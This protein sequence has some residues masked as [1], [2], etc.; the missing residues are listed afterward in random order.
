MVTPTHIVLDSGAAGRARTRVVSAAV[1]R[2]GDELAPRPGGVRDRVRPGEAVRDRTGRYARVI[3]VGRHEYG[4]AETRR[5]VDRLRS[6]IVPAAQIPAGLGVYAGGAPAQGADFLTQSYDAFPWLVGG[7]LALTF[8]ILMRAFRSIVLPL[9]AVAVNALSTAAIYG[10]LVVVFRWGVG[11]QLFGLPH[12]SE[13]DGMDPDL[14]VRDP[15][16]AVDGLRGLLVSRMREA[17]DETED[18]DRAVAYG[19]ERTGRIITAAALIMCAAFLGS[20]RR[21]VALQ[22]FGVGLALAVLID[23]TIV[24]ALLVPSAIALIGAAAGGCRAA[25]N[26]C[27]GSDSRGR[28]APATPPSPFPEIRRSAC[29]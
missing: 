5:F 7:V 28:E 22:E 15:V 26:G 1:D 17:W 13:L 19:L 12:R 21:V 6:R 16:R 9:K 11:A 25:C 24:R 18:N 8:L 10:L 3:V 4:D 14:P 23:A 2:L 29:R 27:C 20:P